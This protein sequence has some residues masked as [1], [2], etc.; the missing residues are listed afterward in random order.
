MRI[1]VQV[2]VLTLGSGCLSAAPL[3]S[4]HAAACAPNEQAL[5]QMFGHEVALAQFAFQLPTNS[6]AQQPA[7]CIFELT[8]YPACSDMPAV[9]NRIW[10]GVPSCE[11]GT[12]SIGA[13]D[14]AA[15]HFH[16]R[17]E[18]SKLDYNSALL[19]N[20]AAS[21]GTVEL[22]DCSNDACTVVIN[23]QTERGAARGCFGVTEQCPPGASE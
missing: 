13:P 6:G 17:R 1:S 14:N 22:H 16:R 4:S 21:S 20:Y 7:Q 3:P 18:D 9:Y 8:D 5:V 11:D 2:A 19:D 12:Y 15:V 10:I 23:V